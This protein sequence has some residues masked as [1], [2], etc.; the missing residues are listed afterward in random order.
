MSD[1]VSLSLYLLAS[2]LHGSTVHFLKHDT[3]LATFPLRTQFRQGLQEEF[4]PVVAD[5]QSKAETASRHV[6]SINRSVTG[7]NSSYNVLA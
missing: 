7:T 4:A 5:L 2:F 1:Q 3:S 6:T